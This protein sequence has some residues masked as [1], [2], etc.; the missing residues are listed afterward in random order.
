VAG[1]RGGSSS[2]PRR[3][4]PRAAESRRGSHHLFSAADLT[5]ASPTGNS[6]NHHRHAHHTVGSSR[7]RSSGVIGSELRRGG[8]FVDGDGSGKYAGL[9]SSLSLAAAQPPRCRTRAVA[10]N[11]RAHALAIDQARARVVMSPEMSLTGYELDT[12]A[13]TAPAAACQQPLRT[14]TGCSAPTVGAAVDVPPFPATPTCRDAGVTV[15]VELGT[16]SRVRSW[17]GPKIRGCRPGRDD[18][19]GERVV[20]RRGFRPRRSGGR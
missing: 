13:G 6:T 16:E 7:P 4:P 18:Q 5:A 20:P 2:R 3:W 17:I 9:R 8:R 19:R 10:A 1:H 12:T 11:A 15:V 14:P